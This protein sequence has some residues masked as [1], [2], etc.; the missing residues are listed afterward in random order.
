MSNYIKVN[1]VNGGAPATA[2]LRLIPIDNIT[3]IMSTST[4]VTTIN[5]NFTLLE[6][7]INEE[8][9]DVIVTESYDGEITSAHLTITHDAT[10]QPAFVGL[11]VD[12][13]AENRP[14]KM[15]TVDTTTYAVSA[16]TFAVT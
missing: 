3:S 16:I 10:T 7:L 1:V 15:A 6:A 2:G 12:A 4:T 8:M 9:T 11:I 5:Y 13:I 14:L